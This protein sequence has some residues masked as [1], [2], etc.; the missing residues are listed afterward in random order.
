MDVPVLDGNSGTATV[1]PKGPAVAAQRINLALQGGGSHGAFTWGVLDRLLEESEL[2][3]V[4]ISGTSAGAMNATVAA[5][6]LIA[7]GRQGARDALRVFWQRV[8]AQAQH[9][10]FSPTMLEQLTGLGD[11]RLSAGRAWLEAISREVVP[12]HRTVWR[13]G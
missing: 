13:L 2:E 7:G 4:A 11:V 6:G 9:S 8:A 3:I 10:P 12:S 1:L 5:Y